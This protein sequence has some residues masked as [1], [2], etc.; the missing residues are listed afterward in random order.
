LAPGRG[1]TGPWPKKKKFLRHTFL[2]KWT[3]KKF[4]PSQV[5]LIYLNILLRVFWIHVK[6]K[7]HLIYNISSFWLSMRKITQPFI[8][9]WKKCELKSGNLFSD[10]IC[11]I[12]NELISFFSEPICVC[13][14]CI[15][16]ALITQNPHSHTHTNP[17]DSE[18]KQNNDEHHYCS[19]S[20]VQ[21]FT[22]VAA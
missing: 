16:L 8:F 9:N 22:S 11:N 15:V 17:S 2:P 19:Y 20:V 14:L 6:Y 21:G 7:M 4:W 18:R 5:R 1:P 10:D 12:S 13:F 3:Q